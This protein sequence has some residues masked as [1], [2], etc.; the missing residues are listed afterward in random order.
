VSHYFHPEVGAPQTRILET[1]QRLSARGH[2]ITV[3][4]GF[5]NYPDGVVPEPYRGHLLMRERLG[6]A[7]VIR[8]P[9]YPAPNR[10]FGR[11]LL[12]HASFSISSVLA[13]ALPQRPDVV[14]AE[15]PPLFTAV[16]AVAIARLRRAPL[17][18]NVADLWPDSAV[19]LG[20]LRNPRAIA[21]AERME[22]FAYRH[23]A[24]I[25]V[26]TGGIRRALLD[27][28]EPSDKVIH[29]ANAVDVER[30]AALEPLHD[31][32]RRVIYC[33]TVGLAQGV[34]TLLDA[35]AKLAAPELEV[36]IVGDGAEREE[37][38]R[39]AEA[40]HLD[41]VRFLGR[42]SRERV[43]GLLGSADIAVLSLRDLPLFEDA[44][45]SKLLEYMAAGRP[46]VA[47]AAG[48]VAALLE[49]ARGGVVCPP[50]DAEALAQAIDRL[51]ADPAWARELGAG[52]RRYVS[53]HY[54]RDAFVDRLEE[55]MRRT[56]AGLLPISGPADDQ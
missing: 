51:A 27:R 13:A 9:I 4:T 56:S 24:A 7:R 22:R 6:D 28:G 39:R 30:F 50:E 17:I 23:S 32:P 26:A 46:V 53:A 45:P 10:G 1:V 31:P 35:A 37:L 2:E 52:G 12:N 42:V 14:M 43:P 48:D 5:P 36:L 15:T 40:E 44:L 3:L 21:L 41:N 54:S 25:T 47:S 38:T 34:G 20:A 49:R 11:R 29:L 8:T 55:I 16:S 18:L 33:G 19:Q